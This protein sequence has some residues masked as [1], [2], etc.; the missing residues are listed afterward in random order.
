MNNQDYVRKAVK[1][2]DGWQLTNDEEYVIPPYGGYC[3]SIMNFERLFF[4]ALAAQLVRQVDALNNIDVDCYGERI[5][6][7]VWSGL[8]RKEVEVVGTNRT[9]NTIKAIV[10][11]SVLEILS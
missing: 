1:L 10:D 5:Y 11:A 6:L 4:D 2:A 3:P 8:H 7:R 9:M